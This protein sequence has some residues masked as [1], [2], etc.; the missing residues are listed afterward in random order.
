M[1]DTGDLTQTIISVHFSCNI[2]LAQYL[3]SLTR[4]VAPNSYLGVSDFVRASVPYNCW[5]SL[6]FV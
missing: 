1:Y 6:F 4:L 3:L 2:D 5:P